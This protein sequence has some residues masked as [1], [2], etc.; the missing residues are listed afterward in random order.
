M[1]ATPHANGGRIRTALDR[2]ALAEFAAEVGT[3]ASATGTLGPWLAALIERN[4]SSFR[5]FGPDETISNKL[6]AVF[7]VTSASGA[8]SAAWATSTSGRRA[9]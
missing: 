7:D 8:H 9:G 3:S 1:S 5:L 2:P 4:P 6:D